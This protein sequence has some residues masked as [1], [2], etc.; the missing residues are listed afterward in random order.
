MNSQI[1]NYLG[2]A[3][4]VILLIF[5]YAAVSYVNTYSKSIQPSA[6]RGFSVSAEGKIVAIPDVAQFTFKTITEGGKNIGDLQKE[7]TAKTNKAIEFIKSNNVESKDI[8]TQN[9][10]LEPRYQYYDCNH[11]ESS[12]APCP[13]PEI[14]GYSITQTVLVKIRDF[15]KIGDIISGVV[16][17]GANDI[18]QLS[19][20]IDDPTAV[21]DQARNKAIAKAKEKALNVAKA[22]GFKIGRLISIDEG[23]TPSSDYYSY[24][25]MKNTPTIEPGSRE[26]QVTITLRYEIK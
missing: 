2:I 17:N 13:P 16:Q 21:Q 11:P 22:G 5:A 15:Q 1:K 6:Y 9:Y 4:V 26:I 7:N 3:I 18:S 19:F 20:T 12:V 10:N 23:Y 25:S 14:V 8:Q 24:E